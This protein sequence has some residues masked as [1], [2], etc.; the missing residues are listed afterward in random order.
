MFENSFGWRMWLAI[1][2]SPVILLLHI[3]H[4]THT[5][6]GAA[7]CDH[8]LTHFPPGTRNPVQFSV[9]FSF[10]LEETCDV[11][12]PLASRRCL[13]PTRSH[14][15]KL[16]NTTVISIC[17][18]VSS[19][20]PVENDLSSNCSGATAQLSSLYFFQRQALF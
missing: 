5:H 15:D 9:I 3:R 13:R 8:D 16:V 6:L 4:F 20:S 1:S 12:A 11:T 10:D 2:V 18:L 17:I 7:R 19:V 14:S